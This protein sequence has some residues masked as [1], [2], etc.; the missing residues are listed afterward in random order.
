MHMSPFDSKV[1]KLAGLP[2]ELESEYRLNIARELRRAGSVQQDQ[3]VPMR[4][5]A[6]RFSILYWQGLSLPLVSLEQSSGD[7]DLD[8]RA[9]NGLRAAVVRVPAPGL[10]F[11][12]LYVVE[13]RPR[14]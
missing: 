13:Y 5:G 4:E 3:A 8:E 9:M 10:S 12:L 1:D 2:P 11:R 7:H 14:Q 6:V